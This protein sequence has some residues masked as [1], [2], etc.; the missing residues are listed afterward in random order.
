MIFLFHFFA[1]IKSSHE[2]GCMLTVRMM[3]AF[4]QWMWVNIVMHIRQPYMS[5]NADPAIVCINQIIDEEDAA[6]YRLQ[7]Q[8]YSSHI[9]RSPEFLSSGGNSPVSIHQVTLEREHAFPYGDVTEA[10]GTTIYG[11]FT[12]FPVSVP[13]TVESSVPYSPEN[14]VTTYTNLSNS[15]V[16]GHTG[17]R[18]LKAE[19]INRLKRKMSDYSGN[20]LPCKPAKQPRYT[21]DFVNDAN[22]GIVVRSAAMHSEYDTGMFGLSGG[23]DGMV[24]VLNP[25]MRD[26][27]P[28]MMSLKSKAIKIP[29]LERLPTMVLASSVE[30][31]L[32]PTPLT[33]DS[34][35]D[36]DVTTSLCVDTMEATMAPPCI[37][38]PEASP[39]SKSQTEY[40]VG[41]PA[42]TV[43]SDHSVSMTDAD[44][45][46][47][48]PEVEVKPLKPKV[49]PKAA[50]PKPLPI[51]DF[52][53][54]TDYFSHLEDPFP[55][56]RIQYA[57]STKTNY[58]V[59]RGHCQNETTRQSSPSP[60]TQEDPLV[61]MSYNQLSHLINQVTDVVLECVNS[62]EEPIRQ[63]SPASQCARTPS[64]MAASPEVPV[65]D[66]TGEFMVV[67]EQEAT[68]EIQ[69]GTRD[70]ALPLDYELLAGITMDSE[71]RFLSQATILDELYQLNLS[72]PSNGK[73]SLV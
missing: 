18:G 40:E 68:M 7:S 71:P 17:K 10:L 27:G 47:L 38:T 51:L 48:F 32:P 4:G 33:P 29:H 49:E 67:P 69:T 41:S 44:T 8:L 37:P 45:M 11:E 46:S 50:G 30:T 31:P 1:V 61:Q 20:Q 59:N 15:P 60:S 25:V 16:N 54:V 35:K 53:S 9:A 72:L 23:Q 56:T 21:P 42:Q 19:I 52:G 24:S 6:Q 5:E 63:P 70:A 43:T 26:S 13:S 3:T 12:G 57:P 2:M 73:Y 39:V 65:G 58:V 55:N 64:P 28:N 62:P 66:V 34:I 36:V 22:G 14:P